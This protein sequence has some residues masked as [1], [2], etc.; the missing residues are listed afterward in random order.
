MSAIRIMFG[1]AAALAALSFVAQAPGGA[2]QAEKKARA[3]TPGK[4]LLEDPKAAPA[5]QR[6]LG[7]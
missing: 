1:A 5:A 3:S 7:N 2:A 6:R 4:R